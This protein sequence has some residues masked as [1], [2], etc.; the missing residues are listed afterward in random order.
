MNKQRGARAGADYDTC[1]RS[2]YRYRYR[3]SWFTLR[4]AGE[5]RSADA[6]AA[7]SVL[8]PEFAPCVRVRT[9]VLLSYHLI[10]GGDCAYR[11][12]SA[13]ADGRVCAGER[14]SDR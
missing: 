11:K 14:C 9:L 4:A 6:A 2:R 5:N 10:R 3:C 8:V 13:G 1:V 12:P 7:A